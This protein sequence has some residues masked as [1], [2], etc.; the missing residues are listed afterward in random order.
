MFVDRFNSL[1]NAA[2]VLRLVSIKVL[3]VNAGADDV[4]G[5]GD[6]TADEVSCNN[7]CRRH[8]HN[9]KGTLSS[10]RLTF[11][12]AKLVIEASNS[13]R[14]VL[15]VLVD[16]VVDAAERYVANQRNF[17]TCEE[18]AHT[19]VGSDFVHSV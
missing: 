14:D 4:E 17:E 11:E 2:V 12:L 18:A 9:L 7:C 15:A 16:G 8:E 13:R 6:K 19:F 3:E 5:M 10:S 1:E